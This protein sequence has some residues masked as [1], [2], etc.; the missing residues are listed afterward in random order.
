M[1]ITSR[2]A[3]AIRVRVAASIGLF[4]APLAALHAQP[5]FPPNDPDSWRVAGTAK[6][7]C[8]ALFVSGRD[9]GEAHSE[10]VENDPHGS[11]LTMRPRLRTQ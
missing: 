9:S 7:L 5:G 1:S 4:A 8:S 11:R 2:A 6:L 3:K 10:E